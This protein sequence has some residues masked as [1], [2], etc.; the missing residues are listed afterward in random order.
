LG[1]D[2]AEAHPP[3]FYYGNSGLLYAVRD[4]AWKLHVRQF[5]QTSAKYFDGKIPLL[6]NL[7]SDPSEQYDVAGDN[8]EMVRRLQSLIDEQERSVRN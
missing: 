5:S 3:L 1:H 6:F 7:E 2:P 4:G 8:S